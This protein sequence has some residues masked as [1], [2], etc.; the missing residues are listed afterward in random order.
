MSIHTGQQLDPNLGSRDMLR[1]DDIAVSTVT[2]GVHD[3]Q[4]LQ[5][6]VFNVFPNPFTNKVF[7]EFE[8]LQNSDIEISIFNLL[9]IKVASK[10]S[11]KLSAG[12]HI[13][14][15]EVLNAPQGEYIIQV[16]TE[17]ATIT[18]KIVLLR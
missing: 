10:E 5:D 15:L 18:K 3:D 11:P 4:K 8:L 16:K 9:G 13:L 6:F 14:E 12:N 1:L 2:M 17:R 7:V